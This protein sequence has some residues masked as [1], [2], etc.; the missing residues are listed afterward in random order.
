MRSVTAVISS[1]AERRVV[2]PAPVPPETRK[3]FL[4]LTILNRYLLTSG[5]SQ[6]LLDPARLWFDLIDICIPPSTSGDKIACNLNPR[7]SSASKNGWASSNNRPRCSAKKFINSRNIFSLPT[8]EVIRCNPNPLSTQ[9]E[10][11]PFTNRSV[12]FRSVR[13]S[14][15]GPYPF[16]QALKFW[17][18]FS[19]C[20]SESQGAEITIFSTIS[21]ALGPSIPA[22]S[23]CSL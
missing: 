1:I 17:C 12:I 14:C 5:S 4:A 20:A 3:D 2:F 22:N 11:D 19:N 7:S 8:S 9:T 15:K 10:S 23:F 18:S 13:I 16:I 21:F 6:L